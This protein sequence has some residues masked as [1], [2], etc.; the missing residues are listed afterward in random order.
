MKKEIQMKSAIIDVLTQKDATLTKT[1][2]AAMHDAVMDAV[3][4]LVLSGKT[5]KVGSLG[6]LRAADVAP[7][8]AR[9]PATGESLQL[10]ATKRVKFK[11]SLAMKAVFKK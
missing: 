11:Q 2:A 5:V 9:N 7:R 3:E 4:A 1:A 8:N 10:E 6:T